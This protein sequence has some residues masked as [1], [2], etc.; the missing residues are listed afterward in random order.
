MQF[1]EERRGMCAPPDAPR[2][3]VALVGKQ[4]LPYTQDDV[5]MA[6]YRY[7]DMY[8]RVMSRQVRSIGKEEEEEEEE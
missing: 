2:P 6:V 5:E 1:L 4:L 8:G 3:R 7:R